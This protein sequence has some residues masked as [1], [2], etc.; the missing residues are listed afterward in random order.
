MLDMCIVCV[1]NHYHVFQN[2]NGIL[3]SP[4][5]TGKTLCLLC[6]SLAWLESRK[7]Q[8]ELN[9]QVSLAS[10]MGEQTSI[11]PEEVD[12][13]S[14]NLQSSTGMTWGGNEFGK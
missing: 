11:R 5:G 4:T 8:T 14:K 10:I 6:S 7:A 9:R 1:C 13:L 2:V 12:R 3:E